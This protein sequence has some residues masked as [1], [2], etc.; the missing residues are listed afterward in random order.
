MSV[1]GEI[2]N[3]LTYLEQRKAELQKEKAKL[4]AEFKKFPFVTEDMNV[5]MDYERNMF[6]RALTEGQLISVE[7]E[8]ASLEH[9][10]RATEIQDQAVLNLLGINPTVV[11]DMSDVPYKKEV[12]A[13]VS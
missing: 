5:Q 10:L 4:Q 1:K 11:I 2:N 8:M 9:I 13:N 6:K 3:R 12:S 7:S